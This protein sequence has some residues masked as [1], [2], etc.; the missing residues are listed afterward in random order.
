MSEKKLNGAD[1]S[2]FTRRNFLKLA[3]LGGVATVAG[4]ALAGCSP[5]QTAQ[6]HPADN[7]AFR[8]AAEPIAPVAAPA[9]WDAESDVVI[10]GSGGGGM[11]AAIR[12]ATA[13]FSVTLLERNST[14]GG[15]SRYAGH[16]VNFGGHKMSDAVQ[17]AWPV[18]PYNPAVIVEYL[19][20]IFQMSGD[21]ALLYQLAVEGPK[22]IDWM[23]DE[24]KFNWVSSN[25]E[26]SGMRA[27]HIDGSITKN[28]AIEINNQLFKDL[29]KIAQ[30]KGV[31]IRLDSPAAALVQDADR[32]AGIKVISTDGAETYYHGKKA[33]ILTAG[34]FEMNRALLKKYAPLAAQGLANVATPPNGTGEC[35]RMALGV[36]AD[37]CG[38]DS[39]AAYDGGV[40][41]SE[42]A[43]DDIWMHAHVNKDG[44][45][46]VRQPWLAIDKTGHRI[47]YLSTSGTDYP[48]ATTGS[49][50]PFGLC[51]Q[52]TIQM[53]CP[54]GRAYVCFDSK[55]DELV[56]KNY[57]KQSVCRPGKVVPADDPLIDRVPEYQRDWHTGFEQMVAA[58][59][60]KKYDTLEEVEQ[61]LGLHKGLLTDEVKKWND[62]CKQG[63]DYVDVYQYDPAWLIP[64][65]TPPYYGAKLGGNA[66][67]TKVGVRVNPQMQVI[68]TDGQVIPGLYA[69][70]HTAGGSNGELS[71]AGKPFNGMF[72]C[73]GLSF[74][75]GYIAAGSLINGK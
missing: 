51:D 35:T 17:W 56:S 20:D 73:V 28:N 4:T 57:F 22:W 32:I 3:G 10:V 23:H 69:G 49:W 19:N 55:F 54:G 62:A 45:Q 24:L 60:I 43:D 75:G 41:W 65:D 48:Y 7:E 40:E 44:N 12:L 68:N 15:N 37:M 47:P 6:E 5:S 38:V 59:A 74:I 34:G 9:I 53:A 2:S 1:H 58:G 31:D 39:V 64:I 14:T 30:D 72:G 52:A 21:T 18:Y 71:V 70:F 27:I 61:A 26:P 42:Y 8:K 25:A 67:C 36:G 13:G 66:W 63:K 33:V 16:F 29:T 46:A 50:A 11:A